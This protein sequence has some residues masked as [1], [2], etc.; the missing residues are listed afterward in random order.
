MDGFQNRPRFLLALDT[1][2]TS[3]GT[4]TYLKSEIEI[5]Q[6]QPLLPVNLQLL[7]WTIISKD[8]LT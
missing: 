5:A 4:T 2:E 8:F 7:K 1:R 3:W 6:K